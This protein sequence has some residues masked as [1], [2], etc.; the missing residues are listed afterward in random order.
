MPRRGQE[1]YISDGAFGM[2]YDATHADFRFPARRVGGTRASASTSAPA[3]AP[4]LVP[5]SLWGPSC[6]SI[7][8]MK[9]PFFVA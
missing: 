4:D 8:F 5:Y 9:G 6:D 2:L 7:D 3:S 1:I